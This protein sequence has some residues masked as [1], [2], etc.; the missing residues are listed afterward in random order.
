VFAVTSTPPVVTSRQ[1][2]AAKKT[3]LQNWQVE[4]AAAPLNMLPFTAI[5]DE[6]YS[7]YLLV[8]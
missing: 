5:S 8:R 7:T 4:T 1:L 2:L 6:Q 3:G